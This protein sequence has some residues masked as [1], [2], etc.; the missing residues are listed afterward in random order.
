MSAES[1]FSWLRVIE[2]SGLSTLTQDYP[3]VP[4]TVIKNLRNLRTFLPTNQNGNP[5]ALGCRFGYYN[6]RQAGSSPAVARGDCCGLA[7]H[8]DY[9]DSFVSALRQV[10]LGWNAGKFTFDGSLLL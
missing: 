8:R 1:A 7:I 9:H 3:R 6:K 4:L 10:T 2:D 5:G